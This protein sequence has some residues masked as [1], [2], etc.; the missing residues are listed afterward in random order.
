MIAAYIIKRTNFD[1]HPDAFT[2]YY[3]IERQDWDTE[4]SARCFFFDEEESEQVLESIQAEDRN[5][6]IRC[7][8]YEVYPLE[9]NI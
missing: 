1:T 9:I 8:E 5:I 2:G 6:G 7:A 3:N 4:V